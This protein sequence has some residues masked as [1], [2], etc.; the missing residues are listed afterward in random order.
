METPPSS[1]KK[2]DSSHLEGT[3]NSKKR[4]N[5]DITVQD[6][7]DSIADLNSEWKKGHKKRSRVKVK[8]LM[9]HTAGMRRNWIVE[10]NPMISQI[11]KSFPPLKESKTVSESAYKL[12]ELWE[13]NSS[14]EGRMLPTSSHF[15]DISLVQVYMNSFYYT[16]V[17]M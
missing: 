16:K 12:C 1:S 3:P 11:L 6:Y 8:E 13:A 2:R 14:W 7:E 10:E 9:D 5:G 17:N 15:H 4:G